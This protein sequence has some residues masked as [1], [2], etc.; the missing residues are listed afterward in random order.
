MKILSKIFKKE[1]IDKVV[2]SLAYSTYGVYLFQRPLIII[3]SA[4]VTGI[5]N[6]NMYERA[7]FYIAL[8]FV[9][10]MFLISY[11]IQKAVDRGLTKISKQKMEQSSE[12]DV[13]T[14]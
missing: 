2:S 10:I 3:F 13:L 4:I 14:T 5:F 7:N 1:K 9:P 6:I 8:L 11:G 12:V